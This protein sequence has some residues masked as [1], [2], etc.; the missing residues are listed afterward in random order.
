MIAA[1]KFTKRRYCIC[2]IITLWNGQYDNIDTLGFATIMNFRT[3]LFRIL[4]LSH[5]VSAGLILGISM[6]VESAMPS[7]ANETDIKVVTSIKPIH[8]LVA[9]VMKGVGTPE[10]LLDGASSPHSFSLK[11]S[12]SKILQN[13]DIVFWIGHSLEAA[14]QKPIETIGTKAISIEFEDLVET[15]EQVNPTHDDH[16]HSV[17]GHLWLNP[18]SA[19][20]IVQLIS[21]TL[22]KV[23]PINAYIYAENA[24]NTISRIDLLI[25][26]L[27]TALSPLNKSG[28]ILFHDAYR[29][30]EHR[31]GLRSSGVI[32]VNPEAKP[33]AARIRELQ[34]AV[35]QYN[36]GCVFSEPQ[37]NTKTSNLIIEG[38]NARLGILD[39]LGSQIENG[40]DLYFDLMNNIANAFVNCLNK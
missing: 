2:Y 6:I 14:L 4:G 17:N 30:F 35:K 25:A 11:P 27:E 26:K 22:S 39:P 28:Y 8:S 33:S 1:I 40:A 37:F 13:A 23:D 18:D 31:F 21:K 9:N 38:S 12:Q 7:F 10:L 24:H 3:H 16:L 36:V 15:V 19:K 29:A 32:S 20:M 5:A 34:R